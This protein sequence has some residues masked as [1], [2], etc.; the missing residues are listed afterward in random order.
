MPQKGVIEI[1]KTGEIFAA[2]ISTGGGYVDENGNEVFFP[3]TYRPIYET[4]GLPGTVFQI[5]AAEDIVTGDGTVRA[6]Q[7]EL[8]DEITTG[9]D[10][11]ATSKELYLG[12]YTVIEKTASDTFYN[13]NGQYDVELTYAGQNVSLTS[14]ALSLYNEKTA[15]NR[16]TFQ[17][18]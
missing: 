14:T 6:Y 1:G 16:F 7:G 8:V 4:Q 3:I 5:Y 10:G 2:V 12:K 15:C 9:K 18:A 17:S 11:K 13:P